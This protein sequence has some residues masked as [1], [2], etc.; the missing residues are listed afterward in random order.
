MLRESINEKRIDMYYNEHLYKE[1]I[2]LEEVTIGSHTKV[3][4][5]KTGSKDIADALAGCVHGIMMN[6]SYSM[7]NMANAPSEQSV[8]PNTR[9]YIIEK[10]KTKDMELKR[11]MSERQ[12]EMEERI[13]ARM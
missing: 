7:M 3:D 11:R 5:P 2:Q 13:F 10:Q 1:L 12:Q 9:E 8:D 6:T 4:H